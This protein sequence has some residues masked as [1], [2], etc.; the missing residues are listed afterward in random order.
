MPAPEN[1]QGV[2]INAQSRFSS[3]QV[4]RTMPV[5]PAR[6]SDLDA[7][8]QI[9]RE[10]FEI[11]HKPL[12]PDGAK[13]WWNPSGE[14]LDTVPAYVID[15]GVGVGVV[16]FVYLALPGTAFEAEYGHG[17]PVVD[18]I[19]VHPQHQGT[20][21]GKKLLAAAER[22]AAQC[23]Y[24]HIYLACLKVNV[25]A[26]A[27]Y[28]GAGWSL[29]L[30]EIVGGDEQAYVVYD[31]QIEPIHV[32]FPEHEP[33]PG[34]L[35]LDSVQV[36]EFIA[37]GFLVVPDCIPKQL[38]QAWTEQSWERIGMSPDDPAGWQDLVGVPGA[39]SLPMSKCAPKAWRAMCDLLGGPD[40]VAFEPSF[41]DGFALNLGKPG[42]PWHAPAASFEGAGW[43]VP[44]CACLPYA[45]LFVL[46]SA[47]N[48]TTGC[49]GTRMA[50]CSDTI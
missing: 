12:L 24:S 23:G 3:S 33:A 46:E 11:N 44:F 32:G 2:I 9:H 25:A 34:M 36:A 14:K 49:S 35:E 39:N 19:Y 8:N 31:K 41:S 22:Y 18:D 10:C 29:G 42:M 37:K 40:K 7:I 30:T 5:R 26:R 20:G 27:F 48:E 45:Y 28:E 13:Q 38:C 15:G 43:Y 1:K 16:G 4:A 21:L 17:S 6:A 47:L 50:G